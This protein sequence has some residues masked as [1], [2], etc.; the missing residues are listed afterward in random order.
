[1]D[2]RANNENNKNN[3]DNEMGALEKFESE[4]KNTIFGIN[5]VI[6]KE[7][8]ISIYFSALLTLIQF[9]QLLTFPF[10]T[11]VSFLPLRKFSPFS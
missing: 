10:H 6:L 2:L 11:T 4:V 7:Y 5:F 8:E 9:L 1:M 3:I